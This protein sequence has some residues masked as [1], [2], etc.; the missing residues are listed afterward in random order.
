V[1]WGGWRRRDVA[2][3]VKGH[4]FGGVFNDVAADSELGVEGGLCQWADL[5]DGRGSPFTVTVF[6]IGD[7]GGEGDSGWAYLFDGVGAVGI[8]IG[9]AKKPSVVYFDLM[10]RPCV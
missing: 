8:K 9:K 7:F 4:Y 10:G 1:D 2:G 5:E 3:K 6:A